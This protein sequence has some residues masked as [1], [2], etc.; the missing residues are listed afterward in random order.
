[1]VTDMSVELNANDGVEPSKA[2]CSCFLCKNS[3]DVMWIF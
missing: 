1:M 2:S 3:S